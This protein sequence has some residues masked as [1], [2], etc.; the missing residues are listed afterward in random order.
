[1]KMRTQ[2]RNKIK[3]TNWL[4]PWSRVLLEKLEVHWASQDSPLLWNQKVHYLVHKSPTI[5]HRR[6]QPGRRLPNPKFNIAFS[7][8]WTVTLCQE[9]CRSLP[10]VG[11]DTIQKYRHCVFPPIVLFLSACQKSC[12]HAR[13][14][15]SSYPRAVFITECL[16]VQVPNLVRFLHGMDGLSENRRSTPKCMVSSQ[17]WMERGEHC[18][19]KTG[20][21]HSYNRVVK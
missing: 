14:V 12:D 3:N 13:T 8:L 5:V 10:F 2:H 17:R 18:V 7:T 1:M 21:E 20:F 15:L 16:C 19:Q 9:T 11:V 4:G 6:W